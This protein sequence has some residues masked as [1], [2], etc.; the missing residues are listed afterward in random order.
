MDDS[1]P[2]PSFTR[3]ERLMLAV[4]FRELAD[5]HGQAVRGLIT[6][7]ERLAAKCDINDDLWRR[8]DLWIA[9]TRSLAK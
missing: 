9:Q 6:H 2:I 1:T 5:H 3:F 4:A 7:V 8:A